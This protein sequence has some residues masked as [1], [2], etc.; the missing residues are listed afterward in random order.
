M[1]PLFWSFF[2]KYALTAHHLS[3]GVLHVKAAAVALGGRALLL[4]GRSHSGK[5]ELA[6]ALARAG[7]LLANTHCLVDDRLVEGVATAIRVRDGGGERFLTPS[8]LVDISWEP[9]PTPIGALAFLDPMRPAG[10]VDELS[11][12][13][14][15]ATAHEFAAAVN[16]WD[17]KED[18]ADMAGSLPAAAALFARERTLLE[19]LVA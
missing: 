9:R 14:A 4:I 16:N 2:L 19:S 15:L 8:E 12:A 3:V 6:L 17:L 13:A 10:W 1:V 7:A 11:H 18:L 5:T